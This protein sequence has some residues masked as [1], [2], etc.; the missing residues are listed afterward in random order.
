[1]KRISASFEF[2]TDGFSTKTC[3]PARMAR[4]AHSKCRLLGSGMKMASMFGSSRISA[5]TP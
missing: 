4:T 2:E 1:L 3:F 5:E